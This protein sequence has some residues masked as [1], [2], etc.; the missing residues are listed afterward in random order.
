M[1][2]VRPSCMAPFV[3]VV[4]DKNGELLPCCDFMQDKS[5][6]QK[7]HLSEFSKWW[8]Q[9]L[10]VLRNKMLSH[11]SESGCDHCLTKESN[12]QSSLRLMYNHNF[13]ERSI[14]PKIGLVEIRLGNYCNLRCIMCGGYASSSIQT[15]YSSNQDLYNRLNI[16]MS[17]ESVAWWKD[18]RCMDNLKI[19]LENAETVHFAGG[20]PFIVPEM[21][22]ILSM[23]NVQKIKKISV[24]SSLNNLSSKIVK[25]LDRFKS[26][27]IAASIEGVGKFNDYIR[28]GSDWNIVVN[29]LK[30]LAQKENIQLGISH[31]L[32]HTSI[33]T[34]PKL[35]E[36]A[37]EQGISIVLAGV[38]YYSYPAPGVLTID[39]VN[40]IDLDKFIDWLSN[41]NG[42]YKSVLDQWIKNY[43]YDPALNQKFHEYMSMLDNIR[44]TD[45][46]LLFNPTYENTQLQ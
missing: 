13:S 21:V 35:I 6:L 14:T 40:P 37:D 11:Q 32:Q 25:E 3:S 5:D 4:I 39:S 2:I 46:K 42:V 43:K 16:F 15:E 24:S 23:I 26:V 8:N 20:E 29:N 28:H 18:N 7:G 44:G 36:W 10:L 31:V 22:N 33:W 30:L 34:L 19:I 12:G 41:Y 45:F 1:T 17:S 38:Y 9:D 27:N